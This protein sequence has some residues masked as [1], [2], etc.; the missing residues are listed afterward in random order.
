[1]VSL[2]KP[3]VKQLFSSGAGS[4]SKSS[5]TSQ[6]LP[7]VVFAGRPSRFAGGQRTHPVLRPVSGHG[8]RGKR[9]PVCRWR[10]RGERSYHC[11]ASLPWSARPAALFIQVPVPQRLEP[12]SSMPERFCTSPFASAAQRICHSL[13]TQGQR[14]SLRV[15]SSKQERVG[16]HQPPN[17]SFKRTCLRHAA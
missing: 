10:H 8:C 13:S 3:S 15:S 2:S 12:Q 7:A 1:M 4:L 16:S 9:H 5:R 17:P 14:T 6:V 11:Y